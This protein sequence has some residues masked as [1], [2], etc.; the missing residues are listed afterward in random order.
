[1][2]IS[3]ATSVQ[4]ESRLVSEE[5]KQKNADVLLINPAL[6]E[7]MLPQGDV[8]RDYFDIVSDV[9][10]SG[11]VA[12]AG[13]PTYGGIAERIFKMSLGN[14]IGFRFDDSFDV[15]RAFM[16][17]YG[18]FILELKEGTEPCD[19]MDELNEKLPEAATFPMNLEGIYRARNTMTKS[20]AG[21]GVSQI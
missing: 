11:V 5:F 18:S 6:G 8:L 1:M 12:S 20:T 16:H 21:A 3:F 19:V 2:L 7:F 17:S 14:G 13:T 15:S 9:I 4:D 10:V